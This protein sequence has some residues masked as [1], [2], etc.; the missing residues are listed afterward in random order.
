MDLN[1][2]KTISH[3]MDHILLWDAPAS[4]VMVE[5]LPP[6]FTTKRVISARPGEARKIAIFGGENH[7]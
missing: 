4:P 6:F 1:H 7:G 5:A 3:V 2:L